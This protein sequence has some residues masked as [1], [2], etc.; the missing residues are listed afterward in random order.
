MTKTQIRKTAQYKEMKKTIKR[1]G[2]F[3]LVGKYKMTDGDI[4]RYLVD[5]IRYTEIQLQAA[6]DM[7]EAKDFH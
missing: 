4:E 2:G 5:F 6:K 3:N 1:H 7:L